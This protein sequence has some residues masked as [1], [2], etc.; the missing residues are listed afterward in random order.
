MKRR[1]FVGLVCASP[2]ALACARALGDEPWPGP[3]EPVSRIP[4][5]PPPV[6]ER[7]VLS[8]AQ[9]RA[10][11]T[12]MQHHVLRRQGTEMSFSGA[13][14]NEHREGVYHCAGCGAP[15]FHSRDKFESGTGWPS[16][17]R[18]IEEGRI[19][20][21]RDSSMGMTR[22]EVHC[23]RCDGHQGHVFPDGP[24]PTGQRYCIN[25]V[26]LTFRPASP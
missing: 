8:D 7:L 23:A 9:W 4:P 6:V 14:W 16:F 22:V 2:I 19:A 13:L 5:T 17:T 10:R 18:P 21:Q 3:A 26:S 20:E 12:R 1:I 25:S 24:P 11:L 15:L